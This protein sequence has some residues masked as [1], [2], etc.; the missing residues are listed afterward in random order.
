MPTIASTHDDQHAHK[1][2]DKLMRISFHQPEG[3]TFPCESL[4]MG[5]TTL[6]AKTPVKE[7]AQG[8]SGSV[9]A[10]GIERIVVA[11]L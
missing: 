10:E 6:I 5:L 9:D 1:L 3:S 4:K 8:T 7:R 2:I 11:E